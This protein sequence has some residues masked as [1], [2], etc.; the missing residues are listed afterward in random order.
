MLKFAE[1]KLFLCRYAESKMEIVEKKLADLLPTFATIQKI[2]NT[3]ARKLYVY[4]S[5]E[6]KIAMDVAFNFFSFCHIKRQ[7]YQE[8]GLEVLN[9]MFDGYNACVLAY[10]H[11]ASGKTYTMMG[12]PSDPGLTPRICEGLFKRINLQSG[13]KFEIAVR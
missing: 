1:N 7:V 9:S 12:T 10:G 13:I 3:P 5:I 4:R 11:S 2:L 6:N 8:I